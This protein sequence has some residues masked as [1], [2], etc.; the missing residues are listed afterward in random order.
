MGKSVSLDYDIGLQ[1]GISAGLVLNELSFWSTKKSSRTDGW[2]YKTYDEMMER[3]PLSE[4]TIRNSYKTLKDAGFITTKVMKVNGV[5]TLHY[6]ICRMETANLAGTKETANSAESLINTVSTHKDNKVGTDSVSFGEQVNAPADSAPADEVKRLMEYI[7]SVINPRE[8][9][10]ATRLTALRARLK[11][12]TAREIALSAQV[13][14]QSKWH[15]ENKQMSV[16]NLLAPTK[17]GR[18]YS[19]IDENAVVETQEQRA[20]REKAERAKRRAEQD[21]R[22]QEFMEQGL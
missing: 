19:Q 22:N 9:V 5:P 12:Y 8:K 4:R 16:D 17:F 14:S 6:Q 13:F 20:E 11:D 2:I 3:L 15:Q 10:T 1:Y 21:K 7:I 18:W